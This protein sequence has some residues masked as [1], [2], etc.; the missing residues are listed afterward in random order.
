MISQVGSDITRPFNSASRGVNAGRNDHGVEIEFILISTEV[1][2]F[3]GDIE[4]AKDLQGFDAAGIDATPNR[5][6]DVRKGFGHFYGSPAP[7]MFSV[8]FEDRRRIVV[9]NGVENSPGL[10]LR[11][12]LYNNTAQPSGDIAPSDEVAIA[13]AINSVQPAVVLVDTDND[14]D[15][16]ETDPDDDNDGLPDT[17]ELALGLDPLLADSNQNGV[18]DADEDADGDRFTNIQEVTLLQTDP[19]DPASRFEFSLTGGSTDHAISF[20]TLAGRRYVVECSDNLEAFTPAQSVIGT[21]GVEMIDL[22]PV[23]S[24]KFYRVRIEFLP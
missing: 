11:E 22:G 6:G 8:P 12:V 16:D 4:S 20:P 23:G 15:P 9:L 3:D 21:G 18:S 2:F 13:N 19:L 5:S 14:G 1:D 17:A 7:S 24:R 10:Q